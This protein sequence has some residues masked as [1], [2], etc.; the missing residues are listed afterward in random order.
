LSPQPLPGFGVVVLVLLLEE[1]VLLLEELVLVV[2]RVVVEVDVLVDVELDDR[3]VVDVLLDELVDVERVEVEVVLVVVEQ[4]W[5][6][7]G[8]VQYWYW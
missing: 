7:A 2:E 8:S 3:V 5:S 6:C 1:L 4:Y